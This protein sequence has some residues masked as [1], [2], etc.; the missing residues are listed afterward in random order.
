MGDYQDLLDLAAGK[1]VA[2]G[3]QIHSVDVR[4]EVLLQALHELGISL[5]YSLQA[6]LWREQ[7][8][9]WDIFEGRVDL[10]VVHSFK[11]A[12]EGFFQRFARIA[13]KHGIGLGEIGALQEIFH[14]G[15]RYEKGIDFQHSSEE[16]HFVLAVL[17]F[18]HFL[19]LFEQATQLYEKVKRF[20]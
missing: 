13:G 1:L 8:T 12:P 15:E 11:E 3:N 2:A 19:S 10:S 17:N 20:T 9:F 18:E 7:R 14:F 6:L 4:K 5:L 16:N